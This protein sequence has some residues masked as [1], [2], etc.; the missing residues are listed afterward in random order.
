MFTY[1]YKEHD[2]IERAGNVPDSKDNSMINKKFHPF[3]SF[4]DQMAF[5]MCSLTETLT[6]LL[7][8]PK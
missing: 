1:L 4:W 7:Q 8:F 6:H 2:I 3:A 5:Q